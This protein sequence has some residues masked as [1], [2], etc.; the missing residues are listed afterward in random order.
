[1]RKF[2]AGV[3]LALLATACYDNSDCSSEYSPFVY[4]GFYNYDSADSGN[5]LQPDIPLFVTIVGNDLILFDSARDTA[6]AVMGFP[7]NPYSDTTVFYFNTAL[8][9]TTDENVWDTLRIVSNRR[10]ILIHPD[11]GMRHIFDIDTF[12]S[13]FDS[14]SLKKRAVRFLESNQDEKNFEIFH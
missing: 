5:L 1:M 9:D 6:N 13:T 4:V 12:F 7:V 11:C 8:S 3:F 10:P 14:T 2:L